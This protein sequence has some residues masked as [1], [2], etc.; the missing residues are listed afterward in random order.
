MTVHGELAVVPSVSR[1]EAAKALKDF[2]DA[3][4]ASD[5]AYDPKLDAGR[6][7]GSFGAINQAGL[8]SASITSP[9]G[10]PGHQDL[11]LTDAKFA[12]PKKAGWPRWF[13]AETDS[14]RDADSGP[15]DNTWTLVFVRSAPEQPWRVGHLT[16]LSPD[17][18]PEFKTDKDGWATAVPPGS[19]ALAVA[20]ENLSAEYASY[21]K[22]GAPAHFA[23]GPHTDGWRSI[24][25]K[26]AHKPGITTQYI[27]QPVKGG[28][29][30]PLALATKDG[31]AM[32]FF[33]TRLFDR[34]TAAKDYKPEI[35]ASVKPLLTGE[36]KSSLTQESVVSE[37][38]VVP[39]SGPVVVT[40]RLQGVIGAEGS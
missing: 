13:V 5:K 34:Q 10:N 7:T 18:I 39:R 37:A 23:P 28:D 3:Y 26:D 30:A 12:I 24:R 29:F 33:A 35:G 8:K 21:L 11:T 36:V 2:T 40:G 15:G 6:V 9:D 19:S 16:I 20:P 17:E 25:E 31:G 32:V 38:A 27:D 4:N 22:T 14:N 1:S